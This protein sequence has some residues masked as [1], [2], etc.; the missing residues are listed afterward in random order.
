MWPFRKR[1]AVKETKNPAIWPTELTSAKVEKWM[2]CGIVSKHRSRLFI[3]VQ[4][5]YFFGRSFIFECQTCGFK[6]TKSPSQLSPTERN[7][8]IKLG[9]RNLPK[10]KKNAK[11]TTDSSPKT[12]IAK[13]AAKGTY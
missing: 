1:E 8:L 3:G 7:A 10:D 13:D 11:E 9:Y 5:F 2:N 4:P 12:R 6:I